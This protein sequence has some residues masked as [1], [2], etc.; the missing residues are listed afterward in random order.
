MIK[1]TVRGDIFQSAH[2]HIVFA[3]NA[4]GANDAGFA[5]LVSSRYWPELASIGSCELGSVLTKSVDDRTFHACVVHDFGQTGWSRAPELVEQCLNK[6]DVPDAEEIGI[7]A[8]GVG[9]IGMMSGANPQA[10]MEGMNRSNKKVVV[11]SL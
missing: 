11:Y 9:M 10:I 7:V 6:L 8:M 1:K 4:E 5:G 3:V 2:R